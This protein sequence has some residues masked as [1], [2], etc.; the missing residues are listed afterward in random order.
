MRN[1]KG[2]QG[3]TPAM[4]RHAAAVERDNRAKLRPYMPPP[5]VRPKEISLW[6]DDEVFAQW[7]LSRLP[8]L[9]NELKQRLLTQMGEQFPGVAADW[10]AE[11]VSEWMRKQAQKPSADLM[12]V[13]AGLTCRAIAGVVQQSLKSDER[14]RG[15]A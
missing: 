10:L 1:N 6:T 2:G 5:R 14:D 7:N 3:A 9:L 8:H 13:T 12:R 15:A 11:V 4:R